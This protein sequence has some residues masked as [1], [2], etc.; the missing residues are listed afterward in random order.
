VLRDRAAIVGIGKTRFA[1]KREAS[2]KR[3]AP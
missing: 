3:L 2:E 1:K